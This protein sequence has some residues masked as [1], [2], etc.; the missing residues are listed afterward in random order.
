MHLANVVFVVMDHG[1]IGYVIFHT[2]LECNFMKTQAKIE[3]KIV[4]TVDQL[5]LAKGSDWQA[6]MGYL[7]ALQWVVREKK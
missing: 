2:S 3:Q 6:L 4:E 7:A 1:E 5:K